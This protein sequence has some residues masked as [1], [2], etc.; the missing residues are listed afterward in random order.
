M[1]GTSNKG[2]GPAIPERFRELVRTAKQG[3]LST[4]RHTDGLL[5]ANPV[6]FTWEGDVFRISTLRSRIKYRNVLADPRAA[7]CIVSATDPTVYVEIRGH[8]HVEDD[9]DRSYFTHQFRTHAGR[10]PPPDL[11]PPGAQRAIIVLRP[12][13]VSA[14]QL[15]GG[16]FGKG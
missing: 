16:R 15:Y 8:A 14:P 2:P 1:S 13:Q 3:V 12:I 5:S 10:E 9:L 6:G 4:I 11:D 7:L